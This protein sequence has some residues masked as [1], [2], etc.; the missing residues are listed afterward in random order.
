MKKE[1]YT[2]PILEVINIQPSRFLCAS[3]LDTDDLIFSGDIIE[4]DF[5]F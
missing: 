3:A 5:I 4:W 1:P 2:T